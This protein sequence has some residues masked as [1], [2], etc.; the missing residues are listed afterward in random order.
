M[1]ENRVQQGPEKLQYNLE[2]DGQIFTGCAERTSKVVKDNEAAKYQVLSPQYKRTKDFQPNCLQ[3]FKRKLPLKIFLTPS[4]KQLNNSH[5]SFR[6][7][8]RL[9]QTTSMEDASWNGEGVAK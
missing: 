9:E 4:E 2:I 5:L 7:E 1:C 6:E 8:F 3:N